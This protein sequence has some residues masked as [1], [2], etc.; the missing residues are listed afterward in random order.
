MKLFQCQSCG[1]VLYFE[2]RTCGRCGHRLAYLP[3]IDALSALEPSGDG[4]TALAA[5][6]PTRFLCAN[7]AHDACNWLTPPESGEPFCRACRH[8]GIIPDVSTPENLE[9]WRLMEFAKHQLFYALL[10]WNLPLATRAEDP[11]H[12]LIFNF[13][14]DPPE[15]DGPKVMTGHENGVIT[16]ALIEAD[17]AERESRRRG[18]GEPYRTLVGHFR[19]EV[20]HHYWDLLV[21]DAGLLD[22]CRAVFGDDSQ[23]YEA[24]L[25]RHYEEGT[26]PDWQQHSVSAYATTHPWEDFAETWA[27]YLHIVDTLEM[28]SAFG[29]EVKPLLDAEGGLAARIDFDPY[30]A[31]SIDQIVAAWLPFVF[32]MNSVSRAMGQG[33]LYPFVLSPAVIAKLGFIHRLVHG[34]VKG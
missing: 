34:Q 29:M 31:V 28:A 26:P 13:L 19:H 15:A 10:R 32:A 12:G 7:A 6:G 4:W 9:R 16:I 14:S 3:E 18:M 11:E 2:N 1:N 24:A 30:A 17:D 25:K 8:N 5:P 20:G 21:R 23:D 22:A 33:D 27:H